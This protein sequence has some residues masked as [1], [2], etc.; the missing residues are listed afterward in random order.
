MSF[1]DTIMSLGLLNPSRHRS[2][3][4]LEEVDAKFFNTIF[5]T[6]DLTDNLQEKMAAAECLRVWPDARCDCTT[7]KHPAEF[8]QVCTDLQQQLG[9]DYHF[10]QVWFEAL[11]ADDE[12]RKRLERDLVKVGSLDKYCVVITQ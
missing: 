3:K 7:E 10:Y 6:V 1:F 4:E 2:D 5:N 12:M 9:V 11:H 8:Q